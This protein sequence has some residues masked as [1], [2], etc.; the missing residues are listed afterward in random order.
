MFDTARRS[1]P[2][3]VVAVATIVVLVALVLIPFFTPAWIYPTQDRA[4][5]EAWTGWSAE[6]VHTVTGEVLHDLIIGPPE[7]A[8]TV[9]GQPVFV[10]AEQSHL[11]D[12]RRVV[13][14]FA[15]IA[16]VAA[17]VWIGVWRFQRGGPSFWRAVRRGAASLAVGVVVLGL[18]SV[19]AF[20]AAFELFHRLFFAPGTYSFDPAT[21]RLVQLFPDAFWYDTALSLGVVLLVV[22]VVVAWAAS[23]RAE[24]AE[25]RAQAA[26][27]HAADP[28]AAPSRP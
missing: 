8:Q 3:L 21:S 23:R 27:D 13:L 26:D 24:R 14:M 28:A 12:V 10:E 19:V 2:G 9:A 16:V 25:A 18:F 6:E 1:L 22:A 11:R 17:F 5:A 7:F 15:A 4:Q 20:D